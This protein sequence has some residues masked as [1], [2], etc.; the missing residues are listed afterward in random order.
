MLDNWEI[1]YYSPEM[2]IN[3]LLCQTTTLNK[4]IQRN[5]LKKY[6]YDIKLIQELIDLLTRNL[7]EVHEL[8][9]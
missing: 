8:L 6:K 1:R 7:T 4:L 3:L 5:L 2:L 9:C